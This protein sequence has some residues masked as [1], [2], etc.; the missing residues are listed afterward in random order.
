MTPVDLTTI[1]DDDLPD[2]LLA[3]LERAD[4]LCRATAGAQPHRKS[5][6]PR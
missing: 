2:E 6:S 1:N 3:L 5:R 4:R